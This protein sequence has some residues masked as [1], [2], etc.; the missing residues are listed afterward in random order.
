MLLRGYEPRKFRLAQELV[1]VERLLA[2]SPLFPP[3]PV[4]GFRRWTGAKITYSHSTP[5]RLAR[6]GATFRGRTK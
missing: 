4:A 1:S 3:P 2:N 6:L 5:K